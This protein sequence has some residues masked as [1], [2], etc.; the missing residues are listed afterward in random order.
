MR[1]KDKGIILVKVGINERIVHG[2]LINL[3]MKCFR[4]LV[5]TFRT[6]STYIE[7]KC[8]LAT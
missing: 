3:T 6:S 4:D 2:K 1:P 7:L 8:A 5:I